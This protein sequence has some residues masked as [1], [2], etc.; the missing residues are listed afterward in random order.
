M[1]SIIISLIIF[2]TELIEFR[3]LDLQREYYSSIWYLLPLG[4]F[5]TITKSIRTSDSKV[6]IGLKVLGTLF[7]CLL[8]IGFFF[9]NLF[10]IGFG[11]WTDLNTKYQR[12]DNDKIVIKE[13]QYDLG[14]LG[15]GGNRV[16]ISSPLTEYFEVNRL[17]DTTKID[18]KEWVSI[19][20]K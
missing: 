10:T 3:D 6:Q 12:I 8:A 17:I 9:I 4:I 11:A 5:G 19:N 14:A 20:Y 16:V 13:Q 2:E 7:L 1:L 18:K 15:Y